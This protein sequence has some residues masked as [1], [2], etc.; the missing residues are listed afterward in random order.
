MLVAPILPH[1]TDSTERLEEIVAEVASRG[2][3]VEPLSRYAVS[4][5]SP[6]LPAGIVFGYA[7][8]PTVVLMEAVGEMVAVL[9]AH[10]ARSS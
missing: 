5:A 4:E 9:R 8:P 1:L 7:E 10:V 2:V 6:P 3:R